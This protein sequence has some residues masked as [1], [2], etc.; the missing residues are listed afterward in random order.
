MNMSIVIINKS[1]N[2]IL[3]YLMQFKWYFSVHFYKLSNIAISFSSCRWNHSKLAQRMSRQYVFVN[4]NLDQPNQM[5][6]AGGTAARVLAETELLR[7]IFKER[8]KQQLHQSHMKPGSKKQS[9]SNSD[10][11]SNCKQLKTTQLGASTDP[12]NSFTFQVESD[13]VNSFPTVVMQSSKLVEIT[14]H[15]MQQWLQWW[16]W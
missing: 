15:V 9:S 7:G 3:P 2:F 1:T 10:Q 16:W 11:A 14:R 4:Y 5:P 8:K 12:N 13:P 6:V